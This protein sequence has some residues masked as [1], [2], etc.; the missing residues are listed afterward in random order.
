[1]NYFSSPFKRIATNP[2]SYN[3]EV[4]EIVSIPSPF[5]TAKGTATTDIKILDL[6]GSEVTWLSVDASTGNIIGTAPELEVSHKFS[7][8]LTTNEFSYTVSLF[9]TILPWN[10]DHCKVWSSD[11]WAEC[12]VGYSVNNQTKFWEVF[13]ASEESTKALGTALA[14]IT[15]AAVAS[16][17]VIS[18]FNPRSSIQS[19]FTVSEYFQLLWALLLL[20][21]QLPEKVYVLLQSF[22]IFKL[23][24]GILQQFLPISNNSMNSLFKMEASEDRFSKI[25][26]NYKSTLFNYSVLI[27]LLILVGIIHSLFAIIY[28]KYKEMNTVQRAKKARW[29]GLFKKIHRFF[30][31]NFYVSLFTQSFLF[32]MIIAIEEIFTFAYSNFASALSLFFTVVLVVSACIWVVILWWY[33]LKTKVKDIPGPMEELY[34]GQRMDTMSGRLYTVL[35]FIRRFGIITAIFIPHKHIQYSLFLGTNGLHLVIFIMKKPFRDAVDSLIQLLTDISILVLCFIYSLINEVSG[36]N[37]YSE[38]YFKRN[39]DLFCLVVTISNSLIAVIS[40]SLSFIK[41]LKYVNKWNKISQKK[42]ERLKVLLFVK[43]YIFI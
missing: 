27:V 43:F 2:L 4:Y 1:M 21:T 38:S 35:F 20:K 25:D 8:K 42:K 11:G 34:A 22:Q 16:S 24:F 7:I 36:T 6:G 12:E 30:D 19:L 32:F 15:T 17:V 40:L 39:G 5:W 33:I 29:S 14:V 31:Y 26:I 9:L 10:L 28:S 41:I 37:K 13:I 18:K 23:D 3:H